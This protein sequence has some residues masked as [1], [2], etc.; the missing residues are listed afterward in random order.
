M[1]RIFKPDI[2]K[3]HSFIKEH[4]IFKYS[5]YIYL[6]NEKKIY[7][8]LPKYHDCLP[9]EIAEEIYRKPVLEVNCKICKKINFHT[10]IPSLSEFQNAFIWEITLESDDLLDEQLVNLDGEEY[11][12][13]N[14]ENLSI[15]V[16]S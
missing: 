11:L 5:S 3:P 13:I 15:K 9:A 12:F 2:F 1:I 16:N 8:I 4:P 10:S 7:L 14:Y 6:K